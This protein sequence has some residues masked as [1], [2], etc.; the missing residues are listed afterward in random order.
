M[1]LHHVNSLPSA[2]K[3]CVD[4]LWLTQKVP[5]PF[6]YISEV[7]AHC[8]LVLSSQSRCRWTHKEQNAYPHS[9]VG[10][11]RGWGELIQSRVFILDME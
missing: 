11:S 1:L 4:S 2:N 3:V 7:F 5:H 8:V 10:Q 9:R 6:T